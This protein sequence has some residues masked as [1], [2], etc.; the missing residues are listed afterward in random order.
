MIVVLIT[1]TVIII[2]LK[3]S[4]TKSLHVVCSVIDYR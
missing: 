1:V 3:C 2:T 4:L